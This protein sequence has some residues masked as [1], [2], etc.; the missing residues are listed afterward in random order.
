MWSPVPLCRLVF[1]QGVIWPGSL[2]VF[3]PAAGRDVSDRRGVG[4]GVARGVG[5]GGV[6]LPV[7]RGVWERKGSEKGSSKKERDMKPILSILPNRTLRFA[8]CFQ[9]FPSSCQPRPLLPRTLN[10][11]ACAFPRPPTCFRVPLLRP[12]PARSSSQE[13]ETA[14]EAN[15]LVPFHR[16]TLPYT[17]AGAK[18]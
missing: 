8:T 18:P 10:P 16:P 11:F 15:H 3:V 7:G 13:G 14:I 6:G 5:R 17:C 1:T 2:T 4:R 12:Q 9:P